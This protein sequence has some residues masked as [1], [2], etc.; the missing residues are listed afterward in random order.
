MIRFA[1]ESALPSVA[2]NGRISPGKRRSSGER[3]SIRAGSCTSIVLTATAGFTTGATTTG[4]GFK[5]ARGTSATCLATVTGAGAGIGRGATTGAVARTGGFGAM[6]T[7][8]GAGASTSVRA[9]I[10]GAGPDFGT[11]REVVMGTGGMFGKGEVSGGDTGFTGIA[12]SSVGMIGA[13]GAGIVGLGGGTG[14]TRTGAGG[15]IGIGRAGMIRGGS[16]LTRWEGMNAGAGLNTGVG[17]NLGVGLKAGVGLN[18]GLGVGGRLVAGIAGGAGFLPKMRLNKPRFSSSSFGRTV[19]GV[20]AAAA[21]TFGTVLGSRWKSRPLKSR[22]SRGASAGGIGVGLADGA[23][24]TSVKVCRGA[25][26][27][28]IR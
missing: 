21:G 22:R 27:V 12:G 18:A 1:G 5:L 24:G 15:A 14:A 10:D 20:A 17:L 8:A 25:E 9:A 4:E 23:F 11:A 6:E 13:L 28:A 26:G 3:V 19:G 2:A 7:G 16:L